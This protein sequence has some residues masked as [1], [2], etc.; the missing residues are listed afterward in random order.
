MVASDPSA[1]YDEFFEQLA[2]SLGRLVFA[3]MMLEQ[4]MLADLIQRRVFRD[5]A[6]DVFGN[7]L[8]SHFE[9]KPAGALLKALRQLGYEHEFAAEI[10]EVI[11]GRNHFVHRLFEDSEFIRAFATREGA[12]AI[13]QRVE[14]LIAEIYE[15]I[16]KLEPQ[17][18]A[19]AEAMFGRTAPEL[20]ALLREADPD[21]FGDGEMRRQLEAL[22]EIPDS[23][24]DGPP[25]EAD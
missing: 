20:L 7:G 9:R 4:A 19:G 5:G 24:F 25:S 12:D 22:R 23:L 15:V 11:D 6:D 2:L 8:V 18:S 10:A 14:A 16:G 3:A 17:V 13:V 1:S 21:E